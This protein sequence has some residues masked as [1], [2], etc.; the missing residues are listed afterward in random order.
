MENNE[1][2]EIDKVQSNEIDKVQPKENQVE[3]NGKKVKKEKS[4]LTIKFGSFFLT[5]AILASIYTVVVLFSWIFFAA[6]FL[7]LFV[8]S[9]ITLFTIWAN[10]DF[11]ALFSKTN[12]A[13]EVVKNLYI[14][15]PYSYGVATLFSI[16]A[17]VLFAVSK[18]GIRRTSGLILSI[19]LV[20]ICAV[21]GYFVIKTVIEGGIS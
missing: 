10:E 5:F 6:Y 3:N 20:V 1:N 17:L 21:V 13:M 18:K 2:L 9:V 8:F 7:I 15:L 11:R 4:P 19:I 14:S 12:E 16:I